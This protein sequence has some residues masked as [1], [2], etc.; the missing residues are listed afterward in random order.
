MSIRYG[1]PSNKFRGFAE[2]IVKKLLV[3]HM[4]KWILLHIM[5]AS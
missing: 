4:L 2:N 5:A 3:A 1:C